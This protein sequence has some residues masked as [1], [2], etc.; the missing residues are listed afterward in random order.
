MRGKGK[1]VLWPAYFDASYTWRQGRRVPKTLAL[2]GVKA[3][4]IF[5]AALDFG[6]NPV[7]QAGAV[8]PRHPWR[9][10]GAVLIDK[11][12]S[13]TRAIKDLARRIRE[14]RQL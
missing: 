8:H 6:L 3:E 13:K 7:L 12:D 11:L 5:Q 2:R 14:N 9:K 4:D 10:G 1:L